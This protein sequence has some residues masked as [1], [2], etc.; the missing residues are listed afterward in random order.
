MAISLRDLSTRYQRDD[1]EGVAAITLAAAIRHSAGQSWL[2]GPIAS[3]VGSFLAHMVDACVYGHRDIDRLLS[4]TRSLLT[5]AHL[6]LG[7]RIAPSQIA[8]L[9]KSIIQQYAMRALPI[10]S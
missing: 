6:R 2:A 10:D 4:D 3:E 7:L 5:E 9:A 8:E 1:E